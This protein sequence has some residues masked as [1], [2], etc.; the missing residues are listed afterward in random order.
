MPVTVGTLLPQLKQ[1]KN[2]ELFER[3]KFDL[4][5]GIWTTADTLQQPFKGK[6]YIIMAYD[7]VNMI[8]HS[9]SGLIRGWL[10][11]SLSITADFLWLWLSQT[12]ELKQVWHKTLSSGDKREEE[13]PPSLS[14]VC[15]HR[16]GCLLR[17]GKVTLAPWP[18]DQQHSS[19]E[20]SVSMEIHSLLPPASSMGLCH[21]I[22]PDSPRCLSTSAVSTGAEGSPLGPFHAPQWGPEHS[23]SWASQ[24]WIFWGEIFIRELCSWRIALPQSGFGF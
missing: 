15:E 11:G 18:G 22:Q 10:G 17:P 7:Y 6:I 21:P 9:S 3:T 24:A 12:A 4:F 13:S 8:M 19:E 14:W 16:H 1:L 23:R 5:L 2:Y 20:F